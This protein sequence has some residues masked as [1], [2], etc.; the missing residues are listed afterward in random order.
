M[1]ADRLRVAAGFLNHR[2]AGWT[3]RNWGHRMPDGRVRADITATVIQRLA[4]LGADAEGRDR[5]TVPRPDA[6]DGASL[7]AGL[8]DQL[9]VMIGDVEASGDAA[10]AVAAADVLDRFARDIGLAVARS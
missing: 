4:D 6:D 10:A 8:A 3:A 9:A 2:L 5:R 7:G 1:P